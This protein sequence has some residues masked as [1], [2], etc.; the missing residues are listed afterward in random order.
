[1]RCRD[2]PE[3]YQRLHKTMNSFGEPGHRLEWTSEPP[4]RTVD[5]LDLTIH[6]GDDGRITTKTFQ[7]EMN[8]FLYIPPISSHAPSVLQGLIY[9]QLRRF[10]LQNSRTDDYVHCASAFYNHLLA[11]GHDSNNIQ[12]LFLLACSRLDHPTT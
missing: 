12:R 10:W 5:F 9:G 4:S 8:L 2:R 1:M 7:K 3:R 11:R 6:I